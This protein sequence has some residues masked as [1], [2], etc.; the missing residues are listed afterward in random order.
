MAINI[1]SSAN[2]PSGIAS[3]AITV[4]GK[5]LQTCANTSVCSATLI[6]KSIAIGTH[7]IGAT[8]TDKSGLRASTSIT[9]VDLK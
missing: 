2:D 9:I 3:I 4:D 7:T 8:A 1:A 6:S 5:P